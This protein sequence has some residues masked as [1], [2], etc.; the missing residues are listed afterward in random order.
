MKEEFSFRPE[1]MWVYEYLI[2]AHSKLTKCQKK[3]K[4]AWV[5]LSIFKAVES[6]DDINFSS[7]ITLFTY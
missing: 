3:Q 5:D 7:N 4:H 6:V 1:E 2:H